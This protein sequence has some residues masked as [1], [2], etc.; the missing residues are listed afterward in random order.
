[1]KSCRHPIR[2]LFLTNVSGND[3]TMGGVEIHLLDL[4]EHLQ[5]PSKFLREIHGLLKENGVLALSTSNLR[6]AKLSGHIMKWRCLT[7][8]EHLFYFDQDSI[9][10]M[11]EKTKFQIIE[12]FYEPLNPANNLSAKTIPILKNFYYR[13]KPILKPIKHLFF[14]LPM[15]WCGERSGLGEDMIVIAR[16]I[17]N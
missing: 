14:D 12:I 6:N 2:I 17:S 10:E 7:P 11:L 1:M 9:I 15:R 5:K 8:P 13:M 16:K 4:I 3:R